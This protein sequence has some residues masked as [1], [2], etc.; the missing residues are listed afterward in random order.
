MVFTFYLLFGSIRVSQSALQFSGGHDERA[1]YST[2]VYVGSVGSVFLPRRDSPVISM[3][4][5]RYR[6]EGSLSLS[7]KGTF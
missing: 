3:A 1:R 2:S 6:P 5:S 4:P 7:F